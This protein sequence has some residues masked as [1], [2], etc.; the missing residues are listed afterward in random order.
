MADYR[1]NRRRPNNK[2]PGGD[3]S[4]RNPKDQ[5]PHPQYENATVLDMAVERKMTEE[6]LV[7]A[8]GI[9]WNKYAWYAEKESTMQ[10][11]TPEYSACCEETDSW[12]NEY[13][14]MM[15]KLKAFVGIDSNSTFAL[16]ELTI[17]MEK[18]GFEDIEGTWRKK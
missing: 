6:T 10:E 9:A 17:L 16:P 7:R 4:A 8:V 12:S 2:K 13:F 3:N 18:Y 14:K 1:R 5:A 11:G 15:E